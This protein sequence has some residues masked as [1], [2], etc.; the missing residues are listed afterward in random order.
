MTEKSHAVLPSGQPLDLEQA[1]PSPFHPDRLRINL[2]IAEGLGV[3]KA[4]LTIPVRKPGKQDFI[5]VHP[6][7]A[8]R[9][10][11]AVIELRDDRETYLVLP[12]VAQHIP[13]ECI[14]VTMYR[15]INRQGVPFLWPVRLPGSDGRQSDW[16]RSA[17]EAAAMATKKWIRVQANMSLGAYEVFE[18]SANIPEPTWTE[19]LTF[20]QILAIAFKGRLVDNFEHPVLKRL[21]GET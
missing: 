19:D 14:F 8:Y 17:A 7:E 2:D 4:I 21:R 1:E 9:L 11:V 18:A 20:E 6:S 16:H 15:C 3:K 12:E 5:R 10:P 13:V